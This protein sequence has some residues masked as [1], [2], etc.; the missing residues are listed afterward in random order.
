MSNFYLPKGFEVCGLLEEVVVPSRRN[1]DGEYYGFVR[2]SKVRDVGKLLKAV[3]AV[4]VGNFYV[5][6]RVARFDRS[7][8]EEGKVARENDGNSEL[9]KSS[10][11]LGGGVLKQKV[12]EGG[13]IVNAGV[14]GVGKKQLHEVGN[15]VSVGQVGVPVKEGLVKGGRGKGVKVADV[16]NKKVDVERVTGE[17]EVHAR[18]RNQM[19]V[20]E[21]VWTY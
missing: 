6:V 3:N 5:R 10:G 2:Y 20:R 13:S 16:V 19:I 7:L 17:V 21:L 14:G 1:A 18:V 15:I 12:G 8:V 9:G 11:D 4:C